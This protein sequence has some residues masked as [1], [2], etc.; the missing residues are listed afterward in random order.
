MGK[1][2]QHTCCAFMI[3][4]PCVSSVTAP[5]LGC[6]DCWHLRI[7]SCLG[8]IW[9]IELPV[10]HPQLSIQPSL[11]LSLTSY[12]SPRR[13]LDFSAAPS[14]QPP[15]SLTLSPLPLCLHHRLHHLVTGQL[16]LSVKNKNQKKAI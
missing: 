5:W 12:F 7:D 8:C 16:T 1:R 3:L 4:G 14:P 13:S 6:W 2:Q 9:L 15:L 10:S 11:S